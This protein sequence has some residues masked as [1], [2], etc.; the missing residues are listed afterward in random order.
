MRLP[1]WRSSTSSSG[2]RA[3]LLLSAGQTG[4][5]H[6]GSVPVSQRDRCQRD[7][8]SP[9]F[10]PLTQSLGRLL[11]QLRTTA[12]GNGSRLLLIYSEERGTEPRPDAPL[13][14]GGRA[15]VPDRHA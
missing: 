14:R 10:R 8:G 4:N 9:P 12:G 15:A 5:P 6:G 11:R 3:D 2:S 13:A 7:R 1:G